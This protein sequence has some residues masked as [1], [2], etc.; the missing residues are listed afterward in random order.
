MADRCALRLPVASASINASA[1][2]VTIRPGLK[3]VVLM[4]N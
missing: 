4:P 2:I 1:A 3:D